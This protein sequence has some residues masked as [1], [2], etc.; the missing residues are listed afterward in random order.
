MAPEK[1]LACTPGP[2][3]LSW[4]AGSSRNNGWFLLDLEA[5]KFCPFFREQCCKSSV[6]VWDTSHRNRLIVLLKHVSWKEGLGERGH[7]CTYGWFFFFFS[8]SGLILFFF[9]FFFIFIFLFIYLFIYFFNCFFFFVVNFVIH[10]NETSLSLH[11]FFLMH[12]RKLQNSVK[13]ISFN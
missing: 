1:K 3:W 11:V 4:P 12:D 6:S 7:G 5:H 10:W 8:C 2:L 9:Y 13:Q